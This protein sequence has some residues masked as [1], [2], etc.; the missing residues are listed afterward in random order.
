MGTIADAG[1]TLKNDSPQG[2]G[3]GATQWP[4]IDERERFGVWCVLVVLLCIRR[5]GWFDNCRFAKRTH[6]KLRLTSHHD[7]D[8]RP[9]VIYISGLQRRGAYR[10]RSYLPPHIRHLEVTVC[11]ART[12]SSKASTT[13]QYSGDCVLHRWS[14]IKAVGATVSYATEIDSK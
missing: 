11:A 9:A 8:T 1:G 10:R 6:E 13:L 2:D 7:H 3:E 5:G 14:I 4:A 12:S